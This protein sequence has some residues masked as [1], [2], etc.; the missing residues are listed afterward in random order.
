MAF[1]AQEYLRIMRSRLALLI[2]AVMAYAVALVPV[3]MTQPQPEL[4]ELFGAWLGA[5]DAREK[6]VLFV[7]VDAS[8]NKLAVIM[9]PVLAGGIVADERARG[10]LD[11]LLSKPVAARDYFTVKLAAAAAAFATFYVAGT[12]AAL[13]TFPWRV[14]DFAAGDFAALSIVHLFAALF[15]VSFAGAMAV[16]F[17]RRLASVLVSIAV[18]GTLVSEAFLGFY[19]PAYRTLSLV[20]PFFHGVA[21]IGSLEHYGTWD[22]VRPILI[23]IAFNLA[24]AAIGRERA[25]RVLEG[26]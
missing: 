19:N 12:A 3:I 1:L 15:A 14:P 26:R 10:T 17:T 20:N 4:I 8:M 6:L 24:A 11:L 21:L 23:L 2:W 9:G 7:W 25:G 13:A 5:P 22:V 18:L 16:V